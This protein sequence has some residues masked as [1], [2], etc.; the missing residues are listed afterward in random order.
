MSRSSPHRADIGTSSGPGRPN[1]PAHQHTK[2]EFDVSYASCIGDALQL[3][4]L[5]VPVIFVAALVLETL[6]GIDAM[7]AVWQHKFLIFGVLFVALYLLSVKSSKAFQARKFQAA[8]AE[9]ERRERLRAFGATVQAEV[10]RAVKAR[11]QQFRESVYQLA[12]SDKS[13]EEFHRELDALLA[14]TAAAIAAGVSRLI[15]HEQA[16]LLEDFDQ[17]SVAS[18]VARAARAWLED[19]ADAACRKANLAKG[20]TEEELD[21]AEEEERALARD[22]EAEREA[23]ERERRERRLQHQRELKRV[24]HEQMQRVRQNHERA[25][26]ERERRERDKRAAE[27][28]KRDR[29]F[30]ESL[31]RM[32]A[33]DEQRRADAA[34][35]QEEDRRLKEEKRKA[36]EKARREQAEFDRRERQ[37]EIVYKTKGGGFVTVSSSSAMGA[38]MAAES[39][40]RSDRSV[41]GYVIRNKNGKVIDSG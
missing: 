22:Q 37:F 15:S 14:T 11:E 10:E 20:F 23:L 30:Q 32:R 34:R 8:Q 18:E 9:K 28:A 6:S 36:R 5:L 17:S 26:Q 31:D 13:D 27:K 7:R 33:R 41:S 29:E 24:K 2:P 16:W 21:Q 4:V 19:W 35:Q 39:R 1:A 38:R 12:I 40:L 25:R 3:C